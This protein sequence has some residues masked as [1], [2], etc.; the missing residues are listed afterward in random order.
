MG[1]VGG[2]SSELSLAEFD[3]VGVVVAWAALSGWLPLTVGGWLGAGLEPAG[4]RA[5][6][7]SDLG[8]AAA[9]RAILSAVVQVALAR[10]LWSAAFQSLLVPSHA[11]L[12]AAVGTWV[13]NLLDSRG[14]SSSHPDCGCAPSCRRRSR[15][16]SRTAACSST[17][18][19][20]TH[21]NRAQR[22]TR[23]Q[24]FAQAF[25]SSLFVQKAERGKRGGSRVRA[26]I[27]VCSSSKAC[28]Y[29]LCRGAS[30]TDAV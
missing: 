30:V 16:R 20:Q 3:R 11:V 15:S 18:I 12:L 25:S 10:H 23:A 13:A 29:A 28:R 6:F 2:F 26:T 1:G 24:W 27:S 9:F 21:T 5:G 19:C 22:R 8:R 4:S 7:D 17:T 14:S